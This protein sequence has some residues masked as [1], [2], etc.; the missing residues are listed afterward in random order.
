SPPAQLWLRVW[1]GQRVRGGLRPRE[2]RAERGR[3]RGSVPT[4]GLSYLGVQLGGPLQLH[5]DTHSHTHTHTHTHTNTQ[6]PFSFT[7]AC[8]PQQKTVM[9][10][11][12]KLCPQAKKMRCVCVRVGVCTR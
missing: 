9:C 11:F 2:P 5:S 1:G 7:L 6:T 12:D 3:P 8:C 10:C 4:H